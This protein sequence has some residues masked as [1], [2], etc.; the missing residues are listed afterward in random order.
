MVRMA[1]EDGGFVADSGIR[2]WIDG[3][4]RHSSI[5]VLYKL[6]GFE[7]ARELLNG[8][9]SYFHPMSASNLAYG[10]TGRRPRLRM[11]SHFPRTC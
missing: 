5:A 8:I 1:V 4:C 3:V 10:R 2:D 11:R 6:E 9:Y 7:D